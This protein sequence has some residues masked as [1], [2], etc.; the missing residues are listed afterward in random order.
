MLIFAIGYIHMVKGY[1]FVEEIGIQTIQNSRF[2]LRTRYLPK[3]KK[4]KENDIYVL[5][6]TRFIQNNMSER[7]ILK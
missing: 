4:E 7:K 5:Y 3:K 6:T 2:T 1:L